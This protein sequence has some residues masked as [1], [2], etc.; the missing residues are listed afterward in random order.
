MYKNLT[1]RICAD[2]RNGD[3]WDEDFILLWRLHV[4][5]T[6]KDVT[7]GN[8]GVGFGMELVVLSSIN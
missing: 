5:Q 3:L 8:H 6:E 2:V 4:A 1:S 7:S